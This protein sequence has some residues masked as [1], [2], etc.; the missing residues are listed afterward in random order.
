MVTWSPQR[1]FQVQRSSSARIAT[2]KSLIMHHS[3]TQLLTCVVFIWGPRSTLGWRI[4]SKPASPQRP[5]LNLTRD[6]MNTSKLFAFGPYTS[7]FLCSALTDER[8]SDKSGRKR[9]LGNGRRLL[10]VKMKLKEHSRVGGCVLSWVNL[11]LLPRIPKMCRTSE[12]SSPH[13]KVKMRCLRWLGLG[14]F[15]SSFPFFLSKFGGTDRYYGVRQ[16]TFPNIAIGMTS[17][18]T[19]SVI[20]VIRKTESSKSPDI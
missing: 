18:D 19:E 11:M 3:H 16:L 12:Y 1:A 13:A 2:I 15:P 6:V 17:R 9:R 10:K 14:L 5:L 7:Y 20:S 8:N 4:A